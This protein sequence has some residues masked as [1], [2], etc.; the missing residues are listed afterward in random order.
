MGPAHALTELKKLGFRTF[1]PFIDESYDN[2]L[3]P[4]L[5]F[6]MIMAEIERLSKLDI[7]DIHNWYNS[8]YNNIILHNQKVLFSNAD[9]LKTAG[10]VKEQ[11]KNLFYDNTTL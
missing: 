4:E 10:N 8:I 1:S 7:T 9:Y 3:D 2:E 11:F 6:K 5:R